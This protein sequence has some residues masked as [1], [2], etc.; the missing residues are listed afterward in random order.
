MDGV[1]SELRR[2]LATVF[3]DVLIWVVY[4]ADTFIYK[5]TLAARFGLCPESV[6]SGE[7]WRLFSSSLIH[8]SLIHLVMNSSSLLQAGRAI[9]PSLGALKFVYLT[10]LFGCLSHSLV[11]A[12][13]LALLRLANYET[14]YRGSAIGLSGALFALLVV[15]CSAARGSVSLYGIMD[16]PARVCPWILLL[17]TQ[18]VPGASFVGHISGMVVGYAYTHGLLWVFAPR[19]AGGDG[20]EEGRLRNGQAE[21]GSRWQGR[22]RR[23]G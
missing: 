4:L 10:V 1:L 9:E 13:S 12:I 7:I 16:V 14:L 22:G 18:V 17:I 11:C 5:G 2:C 23:I 15:R 6:W 8:A 19:W 20:D 3:V 21:A